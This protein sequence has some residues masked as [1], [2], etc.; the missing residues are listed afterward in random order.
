MANLMITADESTRDFRQTKHQDGTTDS[1]YQY[2]PL[3]TGFNT[4]LF[5]HLL[6]GA[7]DHRICVELM[8]WTIH[9]DTSPEDCRWEALSWLWGQYGDF[10]Q[11]LVNGQEFKIARN[12]FVALGHLRRKEK[13]RVLWVDALCIN[14]ADLVERSSQILHLAFLFHRAQWVIA[15]LG[16][17]DPGSHIFIEFGTISARLR[18]R[19]ASILR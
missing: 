16:E 10:R 1:Y 7:D 2:E 18:E 4:F 15:W 9:P 8:I 3:I 19:R 12:L 11:I 14:Q 17:G 13:S 6:L 5:A